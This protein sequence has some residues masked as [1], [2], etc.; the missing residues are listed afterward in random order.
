MMSLDLAKASSILKVHK[1]LF[2]RS[3]FL[4]LRT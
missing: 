3:F 1:A 2:S 4:F